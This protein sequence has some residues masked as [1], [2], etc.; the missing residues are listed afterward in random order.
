MKKI[1]F[2]GFLMVMVFFGSIYYL[3]GLKPVSKTNKTSKIFVIQRG[4][5]IESIIKRLYEE[6]L[7]RSRVVFYLVVKRLGIE[8]RIQAGDFR[9][10]S[11]MAAEEIAKTLTHGTLDIWVTVIEGLRK[12]EVA[13]IVSK[14]LGL[15][16]SVFIT[17]A[18][19][20]YLF[21]DTYLMPKNADIEMVIK[22]FENNFRKKFTD[23]L[24]IKAENRLGMSER[25]IIT[26]AS[27]VEREAKTDEER[28][29]VAGILWKRLKNDWPLQVD[30]T[31]Q[32]ALGYQPKEKTWWKK[33]LTLE[34]LK[35]NSSYNTYVNTGLP[36]TP[37]S[38]P[39]LSSILAV[40]NAKID[41]PYWYY[42]SDKTGRL[43]YAKTLEEHNRNIERYLR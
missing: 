22:V 41:T 17:R 10:S 43:H 38:N 37:I 28:K 11:A 34:D 32:Y 23:D 40:V 27:M 33:N 3:D 4:E 13:Q 14:N 30:A 16:E 39:G 19:E 15:P 26:L 25:E 7:I 36:P 35:I 29:V 20:G 8:K 6:K 21:P 12:E 2:I 18:Q 24:K 31:V 5:R 9:L 42:L 1:L